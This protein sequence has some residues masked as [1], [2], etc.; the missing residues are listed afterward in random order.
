MTDLIRKISN[1]KVSATKEANSNTE[2]CNNAAAKKTGTFHVVA[3]PI[4]NLGDISQRALNVLGSVDYILAEDT[5]HSKRLLNHYAIGTKL[6][7]C[8]EH[9]E[10]ALIDWVLAQL[11]QG[12]DLALI[13]DAG[14]PLISD[15]GFVL[16]R[17][18]RQAGM[19]VVAIPGPSSIIAALSVAGLPS[20]SFVFDGFLPS[21]SGARCTQLASYLNESR[22][23]ILLESSHRIVACLNDIV[24]VLGEQRRVVIARELTK[25]FETVLDGAAAELVE[26]LATQA[27]QTRGEFVVML[28]GMPKVSDNQLEVDKLLRIL[29]AELPVKQAASLT[30]KISGERKNDV[31]QAALAIKKATEL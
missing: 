1:D 18:L 24:S 27:D 14:T 13:S 9:N 26:R 22:T 5:R 30:A 29:L 19:N 15:P 23:T 31:Y 21:K 17:A 7:S 28:A 2:V 25:R 12:H 16:V 8:H 11:N 6:R 4:G 20:D 3:T 10:A